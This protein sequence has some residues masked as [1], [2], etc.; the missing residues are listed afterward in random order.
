MDLKASSFD[1]AEV[2]TMALRLSGQKCWVV[3]TSV[4]DGDGYVSHMFCQ[5]RIRGIKCPLE[6][7]PGKKAYVLCRDC[8]EFV[9]RTGKPAS[10]RTK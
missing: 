7:V 1:F 3:T 10:P 2:L 4:K 6:G 5:S 9:G 8:I